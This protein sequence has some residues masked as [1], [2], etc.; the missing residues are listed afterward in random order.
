M[1]Q[2]NYSPYKSAAGN[3][4]LTRLE[5]LK[6]VAT[7]LELRRGRIISWRNLRVILSQGENEEV[8]W[9]KLGIL[10]NP[11]HLAKSMA[12]IANTAGGVLLIGITDDGHV[13][14]IKVKKEHIASIV[15]VARSK[16]DPPIRPVIE[17]MPTK[18]G[19]VCVVKIPKMF[20]GVPHAV[21]GKDGKVYFIRVCS[22]TREPSSEELRDLFQSAIPVIKMQ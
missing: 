1:P 14:G 2:T 5:E 18:K 15:D 22:T 19:D 10:Q 3:I 9:K 13:E 20:A 21:K 12:A 4:L 7:R 11:F 6:E 8:E 17:T 16:I